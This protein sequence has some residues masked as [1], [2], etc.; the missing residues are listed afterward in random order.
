MRLIKTFRFEAAHSTPWRDNPA[1]LHGHSFEVEVEVSGPC[2]ERRGWVMDYG[3]IGRAFD[4]LFKQVDHHFLNELDGLSTPTLR[5]L[6][7]WFADRLSGE[8]VLLETVRVAILGD[9]IFA[10]KLLHAHESASLPDRI[11]FGFEA[12]HALP[13]VPEGHKCRRMHGHSFSVEVGGPGAE[14][15]TPRLQGIYETLDHRC[16]NEIDGL[17][18]PTSEM[19]SQW[20]WQRLAPSSPTLEAIVVAETCTARCV[21]HGD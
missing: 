12:A 20:I 17:Q 5:G 8:I 13:N 19:V 21:Y 3:D 11:R 9:Q 14:A 18:N 10:P 1:C 15:L 4:P 2:D 16:L 7:R 6:Q